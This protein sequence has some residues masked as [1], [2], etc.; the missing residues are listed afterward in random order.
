MEVE[1]G[2]CGR[3]GRGECIVPAADPVPVPVPA[4]V[5]VEAVR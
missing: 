1:E 2:V 5:G 3:A 4:A